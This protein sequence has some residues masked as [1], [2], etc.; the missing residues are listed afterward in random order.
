MLP[1]R[2]SAEYVWRGNL[3]FAIAMTLIAGLL[4]VV[5]LQ[6]QPAVTMLHGTG[7]RNTCT[8]VSLDQRLLGS[9]D[10]RHDTTPLGKACSELSKGAPISDVVAAHYP[11]Y[12]PWWTVLLL[13]AGMTLTLGTWFFLS[14]NSVAPIVLGFGGVSCMLAAFLAYG[15]SATGPIR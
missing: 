4:V 2:T 10:P 6:I 3:R 13:G 15:V 11:I 5:W 1:R 9:N 14:A 12:A 7:V 8:T